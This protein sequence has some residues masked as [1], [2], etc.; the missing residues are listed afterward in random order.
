MANNFHG[1]G[2]PK[3]SLTGSSK[4]VG[5][6]KVYR[7]NQP[8]GEAGVRFSLGA[9]A[10]KI[11][12]GRLHP[13]VRAWTMKTLAKVGNPKG[14]RHRAKAILDAL[15][16]VEG[17]PKASRWVPDPHAAEY[18]AGAHLTLGDGDAP[19][20]FALGDCDDLTVA[21]GSAVLAPVMY[22]AAARASARTLPSSGTRTA[23]T[24]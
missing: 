6:H 21:F 14:P 13:M 16:T 8:N 22:L 5:E 17:F 18:I 4:M 1:G 9:V 23:R 24:R 12:E 11:A 3:R 2:K 10:E 20:L 7:Q 15:R 19:P